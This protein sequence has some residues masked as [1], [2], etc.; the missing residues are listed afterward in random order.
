MERTDCQIKC[1]NCGKWI[2]SPIAFGN[3]NSFFSSIMIGNKLKCPFC[4]KDTDC[5][6]KNMRFIAKL[7]DS[8][9]M[10]TYYQE[11]TTFED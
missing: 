10:V 2:S 4:E 5:N 9:F 8:G 1:I 3:S 7:E 6:K 11:K